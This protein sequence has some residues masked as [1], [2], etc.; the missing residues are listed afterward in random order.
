[1]GHRASTSSR[2]LLK[3]LL[4][5]ATLLLLLPERES[6]RAQNAETLSQVNTVYV[7]TF[8][9]EAAATKLRER[10]IK[11]LRKNGRL[12]VVA[13]P[14]DADA[15]IRGKE[16]IWVTGYYSTNPRSPSSARQPII[17]GFLSVEVLGKDNET[18]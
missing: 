9:Q 11:Q 16:N 3:G 13:T 4:S 17:H 14:K 6:A 2:F 12:E 5:V 1:M 18:L 10:I 8:G 15:V 7:E